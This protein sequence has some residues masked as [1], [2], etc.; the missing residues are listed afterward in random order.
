MYS[1]MENVENFEGISLSGMDS[2]KLMDRL[3]AKFLL[4]IAQ[5]PELLEKAQKFYKVLEIDSTRVFPYATTYLDTPEFLFFNQHVV[6]VKKRYKVRYREYELS[7]VSY[8]EVKQKANSRTKKW[9]IKSRFY[10]QIE[11][12]DALAFLETH[13]QQ[14]AQKLIP[15]L[16]NKFHRITLAGLQTEERITLDFD[17]QFS[18]G[19]QSYASLPYLCIAEVKKNG[20]FS[21]SPIVEIL[22]QMQIRQTKFSKYCVGNAMVREMPRTNTLK[23]T[24]L[25]L[26]KIE[27]QNKRIS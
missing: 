21:E 1:F 14:T 26:G 17:I 20:L 10:P 8:L 4:P 12:P 6:G 2:I 9:R 7:G 22:H 19:Y 11:N 25:S 3:E 15:V 18:D 16:H 24:F 23:P 27:K 13:V 5:L